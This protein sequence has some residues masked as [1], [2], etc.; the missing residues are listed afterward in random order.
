MKMIR[1]LIYGV[2]FFGLTANVFGAPATNKVGF[3]WERPLTYEDGTTL[4]TTNIVGYVVLY[5]RGTQAYT[6]GLFCFT[7]NGI[8]TGLV[9]NTYYFTIRTLAVSGDGRTNVL[10]SKNSKE[11]RAKVPAALPGAP[12]NPSFF[13]V[14]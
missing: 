11:I 1:L 8:I 13:G 2:I 12:K 3:I 7:T 6:N 4:N 14:P 5:R 9:A 10:E